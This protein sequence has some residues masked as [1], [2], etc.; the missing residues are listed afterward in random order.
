MQWSSE[1]LIIGVKKH[2]E[3]S[4]IVE[5]LVINK[6]RH[7]GLVR[8]GRS[9]RHSA[10]L[11][12]GNSVKLDWRARLEDHLG[13]Y[14]VELL[15]TRA[16]RL[17]ADKQSLFLS[18]LLNDHARLLP[19]RDPH[20]NMLAMII[21]LIDGDYNKLELAKKLA[22]FEFNLLDE[23]GFGLD[24]YSCALSGETTGLSHVSPRTGRAVTLEQAQ[25]YIEKLL[26]L[27]AFFLNSDEA[28]VTDIKNA[29]ILTGHFLNMHIWA[30]R[31]IEVPATRD[32]LIKILL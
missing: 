1:G 8:G 11:Q 13:I 24:I 4:V 18:A 21:D 28:S 12:A 5:A 32:K 26:P 10:V 16:A 7:L 17:I 29:F 14:N 20:D 25:P 23:L 9:P 31:Q 3:T 27:P 6:G 22:L 19:E 2:G 15:Q 30:A